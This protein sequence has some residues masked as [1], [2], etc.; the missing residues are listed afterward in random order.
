[1]RKAY[2]FRMAF[3]FDSLCAAILFAAT[4]FSWRMARGARAGARVKLRFAAMLL[5]AW[6]AAFLL[7]VA[8]LGLAI[9][10]LAPCVAGAILALAVCFPRGAPIWLSVLVL[11]VAL[12]AGLFA[13]LRFLPVVALAYQAGAAGMI[14]A[15]VLSR[16]DEDPR[17][18]ILAA[19][20]AVSLFLGAMA[21][22]SGAMDSATLFVAASLLLL[23]R[24]L[25]TLVAD[26]RVG[27]YVLIGRE[28]A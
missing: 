16:L 5:S 7:P 27:R 15:S 22:M 20:G 25:K 3:S 2:S 13:V 23:T 18:N 12:A 28:R 6:A 24:A 19:M 1:M 4:I 14:L 21:L 11:V 9:A 8:D 17:G 10:L 26:E